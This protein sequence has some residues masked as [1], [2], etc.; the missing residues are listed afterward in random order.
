M[1]TICLIILAS[2]LSACRYPIPEAPIVERCILNLETGRE[3]CFDY[4]IDVIG[5]QTYE[6]TE[7]RRPIT[8]RAVCF[9][10]ESWIEIALW[11]DEVIEWSQDLRKR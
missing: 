11:R 2:F 3:I 7:V 4:K 8:D 1:K 5:G 9:P 10:L 6:G